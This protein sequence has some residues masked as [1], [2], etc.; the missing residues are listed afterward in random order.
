MHQPFQSL[1][2]PSLYLYM[3]VCRR[4]QFSVAH[5]MMETIG[6]KGQIQNLHKV[7]APLPHLLIKSMGDFQPAKEF[8]LKRTLSRPLPR[9]N[10][11]ATAMRKA[12]QGPVAGS[13]RTVSEIPSTHTRGSLQRRPSK[14]RA[15]QPFPWRGTHSKQPAWTALKRWL[16]LL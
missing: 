10:S 3:L 7:P 15:P 16:G 11:G 12:L 14:R 4:I 5:H 1:P 6:Q 2:N 13:L 9:R 8:M